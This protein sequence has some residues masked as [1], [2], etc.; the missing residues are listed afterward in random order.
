MRKNV[1]HLLEVEDIKKQFGGVAALNGVTFHIDS[2]EI[3]GL[4]GPNGAGK[5]TLFNVISGIYLP[6]RGLVKFVGR[7][8]T[9]M[10]PHNIARR[11]IART[12]QISQSFGMMSV[13]ENI[14]AGV[15]FGNEQ[16]IGLR[17][18]AE[19]AEK[20][21]EITHLED[22]AHIPADNLTAPEV[23]RLEL[24][25]AIA[26][27]PVL[28]LLDEV[29]GGLRPYEINEAMEL[30]LKVRDEMKVTIFM[31]EHIMKSI[32]NLS[33]RVIVLD[34]GLQIAEGTPKEVS[35]NP[36]VITA[37]LGTGTGEMKDE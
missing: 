2:G 3:V 15:I 13:I 1:M 34:Y 30:I 14:M 36:E 22:K 31:I 19:K 21:M 17:R 8:I 35:E 29:M 23:R 5:T 6:D 20:I 12:F 18:A 33:D 27:E 10:K 28:L 7:N 11:G 32:M 26:A 24:G 25:R 37:Y 4:I 9:K 16:K